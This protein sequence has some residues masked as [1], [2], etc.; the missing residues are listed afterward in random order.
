MRSHTRTR[1][2]PVSDQLPEQRVNERGVSMCQSKAQGG[3]RCATHTQKASWA[4][5]EAVLNADC[6]RGA[7]EAREAGR[8]AVVAY[9]RTP[10]GQ[11][12]LMEVSEHL[13]RNRRSYVDG[14]WAAKFVL[15]CC[16]EADELENRPRTEPLPGPG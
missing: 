7:R 3:R 11:E 10:I 13:Y 15:E 12:A 5:M 4:A 1:A 14:L 8:E 16:Y 6:T 9:A 2:G